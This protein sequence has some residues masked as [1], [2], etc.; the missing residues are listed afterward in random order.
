LPS[1]AEWEYAC[2]AGTTTPFHFGD[3]ISTEVANYDGNYVYGSGK[4]GVYREKTTEVDFFA[5]ANEFG[6]SDMHGNVWEWC[7][8]PWHSNYLGATTDGSVWDESCN[9]NRY[10]N[11]LDNIHELIK[12][13]RAYILCGGSWFGHPRNC[14]SAYR[15]YYD[16]R[17]WRDDL[18]DVG[19]RL[20]CPPQD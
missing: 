9:D 15:D 7:L 17:V 5:G 11:I 20:V 10:Q 18:N 19:F 13:T 14:R 4:T 12:D 2:R 6:L 1:E 16:D 8:D 3:T